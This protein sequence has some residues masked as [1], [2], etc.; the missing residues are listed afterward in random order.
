MVLALRASGF[1][2]RDPLEKCCTL[3]AR[4]DAWL[5]APALLVVIYGELTHSTL[6][7]VLEINFWDKALHFTA[8]F[9]LCFMTTI[10]AR[11]NRGALWCALGLVALGGV[12]EIIQGLTGRDCDIFDEL[13][14]T[15]GVSAGLAVG[16]LGER[17]PATRASLLRKRARISLDAETK[18]GGAHVQANSEP[19]SCAAV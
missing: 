2:S 3:L 13:A 17:D 16:W 8:Y 18:A 11:T 19:S 15:I 4:L 12:L 6:V 14:N 5:V 10:A 1:L 9:G 7:D